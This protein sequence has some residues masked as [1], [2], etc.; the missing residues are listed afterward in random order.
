MGD[1]VNRWPFD[2]TDNPARIGSETTHG[3]LANMEDADRRV[4]IE[5]DSGLNIRLEISVSEPRYHGYAR[6]AFLAAVRR[7]PAADQMSS[8]SLVHLRSTVPTWYHEH[9]GQTSL[10]LARE[11]RQSS[12]ISR[13]D[14]KGSFDGRWE[15]SRRPTWDRV[16]RDQAALKAAVSTDV[17]EAKPSL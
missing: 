3:W 2:I 12:S 11:G 10:R 17:V 13:P 16:E 14:A 9:A 7:L 5:G 6:I 4:L 15:N 1:M 8:R